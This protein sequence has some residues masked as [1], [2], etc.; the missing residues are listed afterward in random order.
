MYLCVCVNPAQQK[1]F[2]AKGLYN[3]GMREVC[4]CSGIFIADEAVLAKAV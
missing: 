1:D 2:W 4:E 3:G